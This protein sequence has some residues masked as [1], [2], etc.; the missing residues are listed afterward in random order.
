MSYTVTSPDGSDYVA[1]PAPQINPSVRHGTLV[2]ARAGDAILWDSRLMHCNTPA[3][4]PPS[5]ALGYAENELLRAAIYVCMT[6]RRFADRA[7]LALRR[8]A[9]LA[10]V[11]SSHWPHGGGGACWLDEPRAVGADLIKANTCMRSLALNVP[12]DAC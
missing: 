10:G 2:C 7:T 1:V 4:E 9:A 3:L 6:P 11:G 8:S 12:L 5:A